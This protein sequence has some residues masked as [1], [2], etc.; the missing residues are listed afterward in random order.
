MTSYT[1]TH[2]DIRWMSLAGTC[3]LHSPVHT[4]LALTNMWVACGTVHLGQLL[5]SPG[6]TGFI[7]EGTCTKKS[8]A[9]IGFQ[10]GPRGGCYFQ[11]SLRHQSVCGLKI[12]SM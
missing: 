2:V 11:E 7:L 5:D 8:R 10:E 1:H 3:T 6:I 12:M 9:T 4:V